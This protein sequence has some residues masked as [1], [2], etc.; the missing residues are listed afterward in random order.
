M[1]L[2]AFGFCTFE[3]GLSGLR[4]KKVLS[5]VDFT[6]YCPDAKEAIQVKAGTKET[7]ALESMMEV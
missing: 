6:R 7:A 2:K 5:T 1:D 3:H 4:C